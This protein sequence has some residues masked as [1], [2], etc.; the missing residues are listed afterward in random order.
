M[1]Q[2]IPA[3]EDTCGKRY[4][5]QKVFAAE[6]TCGRRCPRQKVFAAE[7]IHGKRYL[8]QEDVHNKDICSRGFTAEDVSRERRSR[9]L[10]TA[11][12]HKR[13]REGG[14]GLTKMEGP[15]TNVWIGRDYR[16][17]RQLGKGGEGTVYLVQHCPTEQ[18]RAAKL[19]KT[20]VPGRRLHELNMMK[21]LKHPALPQ[22]FDA[23]EDQGQ[24]WLILEYVRGKPLSGLTREELTPEVF[25]S[26]A[27]QLTEVLA[28]LHTRKPPVLHLDIK[29]SNLLLRTDGH[30][31]LIDFGAADFAR[32]GLKLPVCYG[33]PGFAAPEQKKTGA[34]IDARADFYGLGAALYYCLYGSAPGN[35]QMYKRRIFRRGAVCC[36]IDDSKPQRGALP[37]ALPA[38]GSGKALAG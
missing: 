28:Y 2:K 35:K 34:D 5:R 26:A 17:I 3:A 9:R 37:G 24:L 31:M 33:T 36:R 19:L 11:Y 18:L 20:D 1:R 14:A 22:I 7:D 6:D 25:F 13:E 23:F 4:P 15:D 16:K 38:D 29:P 21:R 10:Q 27:R 8:Q 12:Q 30:L 32:P